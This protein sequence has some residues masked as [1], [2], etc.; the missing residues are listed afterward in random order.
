MDVV[1]GGIGFMNAPLTASEVRN[2]KK[3]LGNLVKDPVG[4]ANQVYQFLGP[5]IYTWEEL[6]S[7]LNIL[8]SAEETRLI[9]TAGIRIWQ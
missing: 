7:I 5:H 6:N 9:R 4:I 3:E 1:A 8:F 2:F